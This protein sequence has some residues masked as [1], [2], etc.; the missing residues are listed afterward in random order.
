MYCK[1]KMCNTIKLEY[2]LSLQGPGE[3]LSNSCPELFAEVTKSCSSSL[4]K[5][6]SVKNTSVTGEIM[7]EEDDFF[8]VVLFV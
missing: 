4:Q 6:C 8:N 7:E 2:H 5:R 1:V 3:F